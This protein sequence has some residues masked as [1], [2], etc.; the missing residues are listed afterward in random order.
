MVEIIA[1]AG[2][3][4]GGSVEVALKLAD[5]ARQAGAD[6]VKFQTYVP[7]SLYK[8]P[9]PD[10][11]KCALSY[12]EFKHIARH[13]EKIGIEFMSTPGDVDS[14]KFLIEECGVKR[15]KIGSDDLTYKPLIWA[16]KR[17]GLPVILSTGMANNW[18]IWDVVFGSEERFVDLTLMH[19]ISL[20]PT[21]TKDA[22]LAYINWLKQF[23]VHVGYSDHTQTPVACLMAMAM[24]AE[25][26][27][28]H[29]CPNNYSGPDANVS[30]MPIEFRMFVANLR[31]SEELLGGGFDIHTERPDR[32]NINKFRKGPDG[33]R[34]GS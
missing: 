32:I 31:A 3:T 33:L 5:S 17:T 1:E 14:L 11:V 18:E 8:E 22:N 24:G 15:I 6:A 10:L 29:I 9:P 13:C 34:N 25:V 27:E 23:D 7:H 30:R 16:A 20:Y 4:H 26:I 21:P 28:S 12:P 19:C 2:I